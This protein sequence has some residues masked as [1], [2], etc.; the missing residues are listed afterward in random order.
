VSGSTIAVGSG[1]TSQLT[2]VDLSGASPVDQTYTL[3][4]VVGGGV[5]AAISASDWF[6]GGN[7]II[8]DGT[9]IATT[10][11]YLDYGTALSVAGAAGVAAVAT[12]SGIV[13][14]NVQTNTIEVTIPFVS[15]N[16]QLSANATVLAASQTFPNGYGNALNVYSLPSGSL[17]YSFPYTTGSATQLLA[18]TLA[19][20]G[21]LIGQVTAQCYG[22][23]NTQQVTAVTGGAVLWSQTQTPPHPGT[24]PSVQFSP[25]STLIAAS[26]NEPYDINSTQEAEIAT[27]IY[28]N[29]VLAEAVPGWAV[30]WISNTE[31][32]TNTYTYSPQDSPIGLYAGATIY[33]PAGT[34][35]ATPALPQLTNLVPV[36]ADGTE[37]YSPTLNSIY[38]IPSGT[39]V[40]GSSRQ[41]ELSGT[42]PGAF[43]SPDMVYVWGSHVVAV[44]PPQ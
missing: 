38:S 31:L 33:S 13:V 39:L 12:A 19:P 41:S 37:I 22:C 2:I 25:D 26:N 4:A 21:T 44:Q 3:P 40:F 34:A 8:F 36:N 43:A 29:Y 11:K 15:N 1:T 18:Y 10:P 42:T 35:A 32:L 23:A 17:I 14:I 16:V 5:F 27:N 30:G 20:T 6:V 7:G 24:L 9:S 28:K